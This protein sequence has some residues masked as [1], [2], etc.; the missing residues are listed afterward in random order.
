MLKSGSRSKEIRLHRMQNKIVKA[1]TQIATVISSITDESL[2]KKAKPVDVN[3]LITNLFGVV[4]ILGSAIQ[5]TSQQ[6][7]EG[8][9]CKS[10]EENGDISLISS[11]CLKKMHSH[12]HSKF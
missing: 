4:G 12:T 3:N 10:R 1:T 5:D 6:R 7:K 9:V 11:F 8:I 2:G